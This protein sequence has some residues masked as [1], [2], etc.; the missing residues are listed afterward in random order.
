[1]RPTGH[2]DC[3][4]QADHVTVLRVSGRT[5]RVTVSGPER[6]D[7]SQRWRSAAQC[8][9]RAGLRP[10]TWRSYVAR[11][12]APAADDPDLDYPV[13]RRRPRWLVSTI[14]RW[15]AL[16]PGLGQ[17]NSR[18]RRLELEKIRKQLDGE[19]E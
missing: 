7:E 1:M 13:N 11:G 19:A 10:G 3:A 17:S 15:E 5:G 18:L 8:A 2:P 6:A 16:R 14:E 12:L 9:E 4:R